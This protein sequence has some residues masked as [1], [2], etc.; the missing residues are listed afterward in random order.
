MTKHHLAGV[1]LQPKSIECP[2]EYRTQ[3]KRAILYLK[4]VIRSVCHVY[5]VPPAPKD[6]I[7]DGGTNRIV[8]DCLLCDILNGNSNQPNLP[9]CPMVI[10]IFYRTWRRLTHVYSHWVSFQGSKRHLAWYSYLLSIKREII[11]PEKTAWWKPYCL[12]A[13]RHK[14]SCLVWINWTLFRLVWRIPGYSSIDWASTRVLI[15]VVKFFSSCV[16]S[17]RRL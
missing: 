4:M 9:S 6:D 12:R 16:L 5:R 8:S 2:E 10:S 7:F 1:A 3:I 14:Q 11:L 17:L 15:S 13:P